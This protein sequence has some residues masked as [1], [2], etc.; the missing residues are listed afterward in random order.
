VREILPGLFHWTARHPKIQIEV[1]S[2]WW[3]DGRVL[4]DPLLPPGGVG[5]FHGAD[6]E[7]VILTNRHHWRH[8]SELVAALGCTVWCNEAGLHEFTHGEPV[9]GFR[10][11]AKLPGGIES[12]P[13]GV[14][15]PDETALRLPVA[16]GA[17]AVA[18]GVVRDHGGPLG[19]VPDPLLGDD[20][21]AVKKGLREVYGELCSRLEFDALLLAHGLPMIRGGRAAL[22]HFA[23]GQVMS[24]A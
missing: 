20:P 8:S 22:A 7:H 2:Y 3:R 1:S 4:L 21:A 15:C 10:A 12:H 17:L 5:A 23:R 6:P 24:R 13:V 14:L 16:G 9:R 19:F 18:D 11:G